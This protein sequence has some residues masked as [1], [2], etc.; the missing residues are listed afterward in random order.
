MSRVASPAPARRRVRG[1]R[2]SRPR[3]L[4][5]KLAA[6]LAALAVGLV[7]APASSAPPEAGMLVP[8]VSLGGVEL[9]MTT[10]Q[11]LDAWG[12]RHGVCRDCAETTWYFNFRP[13]APEGAGVAFR[14]GRVER[15]FTVWKPAG[16][17]TADGLT[18][19]ASAAA[20]EDL[21][22]VQDR[23]ECAGYTALL[24]P[25]DEVATVFYLH[26]DELWGFGLVRRGATPCL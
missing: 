19:G 3:L 9:G 4:Q 18:L 14:R 1:A 22:G 10:R 5:H 11:V 23:F 2:G 12:S 21:P 20:V 24:A 17:R 25:Q 13:F 8:G 16:W 15:V 7:A 26:R 6:A